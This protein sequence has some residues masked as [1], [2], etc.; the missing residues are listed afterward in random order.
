MADRT[1]T[2]CF[3]QLHV[4]VARNATDD[5]I[6]STT[7][8]VGTKLETTHSADQSSWDFNSLPWLILSSR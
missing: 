6:P 5:L 2:H 8:T 1:T 3:K 4:D 7:L